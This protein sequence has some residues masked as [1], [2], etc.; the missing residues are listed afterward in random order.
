ME[1]ILLSKLTEVK[2]DYPYRF[3]GHFDRIGRHKDDMRI[4]LIGEKSKDVTDSVEWFTCR[5]NCPVFGDYDYVILYLPTLTDMVLKDYSADVFETIK[6]N[7]FNAIRNNTRIYI[8]TAPFVKHN[9]NENYRM[10]PFKIRPD[11]HGG[12]VYKTDD[13]HDYFSKVKKWDFYF[14]GVDE[15]TIKKDD[16][17]LILWELTEIAKTRHGGLISFD[18]ALRN[19]K[20]SHLT[21][22]TEVLVFLPPQTDTTPQDTIKQILQII[23]QDKYEIPNFVDEIIIPGEKDIKEVI[24]ENNKTIEKAQVTLEDAEKE[25]KSLR[26]MKGILSL[27][28]KTLVRAVVKVCSEMGIKLEGKDIYEEDKTFVSEKNSIPVEIKGHKGAITEKDLLQVMGRTN[29]AKVVDEN[30]T[31]G[32]LIANPYCEKPLIE[33]GKDFEPGI[34]K[35][36]TAWEVCLISTKTLFSYWA[37]FRKTGNTKLGEKLLNTHGVLE[38]AREKTEKT[39]EHSSK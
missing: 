25:Y 20:F 19:Y 39:T 23:V 18:I 7:I 12:I 8:V 16:I 2:Q 24:V 4:L 38:Y 22:T 6:S 36:A 29:K 5:E 17:H 21:S 30:Y 26:F 37:D 1:I 28:D 33:R 14:T 3:S 15:A 9:D 10:F 27:K 35:K 11:N 31:K 34:I 13:F 32:I